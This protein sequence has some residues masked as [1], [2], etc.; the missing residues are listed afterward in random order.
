MTNYN[1][2]RC[3][4]NT[5]YKNDFRKHIYRKFTCK[6]ILNKI[7]ISTIIKEFEMNKPKKRLQNDFKMT[8]ND[9]EMTSK[10]NKIGKNEIKCEFCGKTFT[11]RN[12]LNYHI[13]KRCK[14]KKNITNEIDKMKKEIEELKIT[15]KI[16]NNTIKNNQINSNNNIII[17][18]FGN[19]N[20]DYITDNM[21]KN[22]LLQG[23]NSIPCLIKQIH[24]NPEHPENHNIRIKNK[25]LKYAEVRENNEWKYKHKKAVLDDL[26]DFGYVT[27]EEFKDNNE[28]KLDKLLIKGFK[29]MMN[30]YE[31]NKKKIIDNIELEVLNGMNSIEI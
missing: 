9:F 15:N 24:F 8:S 17:N 19:E 4:Y 30:S 10:K 26:V 11:R 21:L 16:I 31:S 23:S 1:C 22:L 13:K 7:D 29:R 3:G 28:E 12:N 25:K 20:M 5:K 2:R 18:N 27:L 14:L 6:P